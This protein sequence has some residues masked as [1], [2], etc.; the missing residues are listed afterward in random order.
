[1][2]VGG[3]PDRRAENYGDAAF[4]M[5]CEGS[6][7]APRAPAAAP[8]AAAA[9]PR[10]PPELAADL[11]GL[12]AYSANRAAW[13]AVCGEEH[14]EG[15]LPPPF[16]RDPRSDCPRLDAPFVTDEVGSLPVLPDDLEQA[17]A[18]Y[19]PE[20]VE[21]ASTGEGG[22]TEAPEVGVDGSGKAAASSLR[23][24]GLRALLREADA[25]G[26][27]YWATVACSRLRQP[28]WWPPA[29]CGPGGVGA[30]RGSVPLYDQLIMGRGAT[31]IGM[32]ADAYSRHAD[33]HGGEGGGEGGG[34][35][36][37]CEA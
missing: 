33:A 19:L 15:A 16:L 37:G 13:R 11:P 12:A 14:S 30:G 25:Q 28:P 7:T 8:L 21:E 22:A 34:G 20:A 5:W 3:K 10:H 32:H 2:F 24:H 17:L 23:R 36:G 6:G 31:G 1:M 9:A 27:R 29:A 18:A 4:E 35:G 26:Q